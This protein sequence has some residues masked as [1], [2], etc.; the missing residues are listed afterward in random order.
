MNI[1][2]II[3]REGLVIVILLVVSGVSLMLNALQSRK[4]DSKGNVYLKDADIQK[5]GLFIPQEE[6]Q[7]SGF[8][9]STAIPAD[10]SL[11]RNDYIA[12]AKQELLNRS[13]FN[14]VEWHFF[15][16][17][18]L[19]KRFGATGGEKVDRYYKEREAVEKEMRDWG[20]THLALMA[21][22]SLKHYENA[23]KQI[24]GLKQKISFSSVTFFFALLAYPFYL[25]IRF[26]CWAINMLKS[27]KIDGVRPQQ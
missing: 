26:I 8:E 11:S 17:D 7:S 12:L 18:A 10:T 16:F 25:L 14:N 3:A 22:I 15:S 2:R 19:D 24:G 27:K 13:G 20:E 21:G 4:F 1:K 23:T 5:Y 9:I 6:K